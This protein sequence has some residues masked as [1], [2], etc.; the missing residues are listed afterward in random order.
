MLTKII[1]LIINYYKFYTFKDKAW[2]TVKKK[3][4]SP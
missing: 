2:L 1:K 3:K 4:E